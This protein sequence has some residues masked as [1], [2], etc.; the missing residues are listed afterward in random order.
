MMMASRRQAALAVAAGL[1]ICG[2]TFHDMLDICASEPSV[3]TLDVVEGFSGVGSIR[4]A[5]ADQR[6]RANGFDNKHD[7]S[8][9]VLEREGVVKAIQMIAK[10][11]VNGLLW[12]APPCSSFCGL[13]TGTSGR[14]N[15]TPYG[16]EREFVK[17]GNSLARVAL[18]LF[19]L[20]YVRGCIVVLENPSGNL[21]WRLPFIERLW[22]FIP[23]MA[24]AVCHRC[25]FTKPGPN[26]YKKPFRIVSPTLAVEGMSRDCE[27]K[28]KTCH[29][30]LVTVK[31]TDKKVQRTGKSKALKDSGAYPKKMGI[32]LVKAWINYCQQIS[33]DSQ[34]IQ[35]AVL[36][37]K[38]NLE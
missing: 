10:L 33:S 36:S 23:T 14:S 19:L 25:A 31:A 22:K 17:E 27:C 32:F 29:Q 35:P 38:S 34:L 20:G 12:L 16:N 15:E 28:T 1:V 5:A 18:M 8:F 30:S 21:F 2:L 9:N 3:Q 6:L 37:W 7:P 4:K 24:S 13:C 26:H 11:R